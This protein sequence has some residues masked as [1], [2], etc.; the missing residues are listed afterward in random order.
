MR[1]LSMLLWALAGCGGAAVDG[2]E[3]GRLV[4]DVQELDF[5]AVEMGSTSTLSVSLSNPGSTSVEV[6]SV[7]LVEGSSAVWQVDRNGVEVLVGGGQ[8]EIQVSFSPSET[9]PEA[10]RVQIRSSDAEDPSQFVSVV[11][12]GA[13]STIDGDG[14]GFSPA[15]GDC[16][17]ENPAVNPGAAEI[18][19]ELDTDCDGIVPDDEADDDFDGFPICAGD[20]DDDAS[21]VYPGAVEI[22]DGVDNDC[23]PGGD[24]NED[25]DGD[26]ETP[27]DG[28]CDDANGAVYSGAEEV[29]DG[30]D[31]D[32]DGGVDDLDADGDGHSR[33]S[34]TGDC[35]D[36]D[37]DAYPVV[38]S[39]TGNT[40]AAGTDS[41]PFDTIA[42]ALANLDQV[43]H[44]IHLQPGS[45]ELDAQI[46][47]DFL[48]IYGGSP[49]DTTLTAPADTRLML[50]SNGADVLV[51][52]VTLTGGDALTDGGA[53]KVE[54]GATLTLSS[55]I[56]DGNASATDGGA[57][58]VASATLILRGGCSFLNNTAL[59]DGG[60]IALVS[61]VMFSDRGSTYVSNT[62]G[63]AGAISIFGG[64]VDATDQWFESN[65]TT[66][67]D[68]G[69]VQIS[70]GGSFLVERGHFQ[71]NTAAGAGGAM[72]LTDVDDPDGWVRNLTAATNTSAADGG[73]IAV[74]GATAALGIANNT[75]VGN[76]AS[77]A[78]GG[79][80]H[81]GVS[82]A[83]GL[84]VRANLIGWT[85]GASGLYL[86]PGS[87]AWVDHNTSFATSTLVDFGGALSEGLDENLSRD[88]L[89]VVFTDDG[90]PG[91]DDLD[92]QPGSLE[93]DAG[94]VEATMND[95]DGSRND[96]GATGGPGASP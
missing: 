62:A 50:I 57:I 94:P 42:T 28:D 73:A 72:A 80:L 68:G 65:S 75:L 37:P 21:D 9:T 52:G 20:C 86:A 4:V 34:E 88:P 59:D 51:D 22:C 83:A 54:S 58:A 81:V 78:E 6:L 84:E 41:D 76:T 92:L 91:N 48:S 79:A 82:D 23:V 16:D 35:D 87:T 15:E 33:C 61:P 32:C 30:F 8:A 39:T 66:L 60:A 13:L 12:S 70:G 24:E 95:L 90:V 49:A 38:V 2:G 44:E 46:S 47:A 5:G 10:G 63:N 7:S 74:N 11:G 3:E 17:D 93:R 43:C 31:N 64:T 19:D 53:I 55:V 89:F 25:N 26:G 96:R 40:Y 71:F 36:S 69:A 85:N 56:A 67:G 14:D 1:Y 29:C 27:C 18:C 45:Y 77:G